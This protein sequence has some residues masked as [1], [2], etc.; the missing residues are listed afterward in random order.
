LHTGTLRHIWKH[1]HRS[2]ASVS[3]NP[4]QVRDANL[5]R[6]A[7]EIRNCDT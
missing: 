1:G 5:N 7:V 3:A 2:R 6:Q 4:A